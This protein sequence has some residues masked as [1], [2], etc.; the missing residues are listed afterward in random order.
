M[1]V[2]PAV[3][4]GQVLD[5]LFNDDDGLL[6]EEVPEIQTVDFVSI[7]LLMETMDDKKC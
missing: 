5:L 6:K 7:L 4:D 2:Q 1:A 3:T